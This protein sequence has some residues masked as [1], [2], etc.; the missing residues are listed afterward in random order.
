MGSGDRGADRGSG[1]ALVAK[2]PPICSARKDWDTQGTPS[3]TNTMRLE[4][5]KP[6]ATSLVA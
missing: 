5:P 2:R 6:D 1:E 4:Q 3:A